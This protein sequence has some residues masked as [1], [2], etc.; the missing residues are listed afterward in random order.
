MINGVLIDR[1]V[2]DVIPALKTNLEGLSKVLEDLVKQYKAK[3]EE[4]EKWKVVWSP[5]LTVM[6]L[7]A[8]IIGKVTE[9]DLLRE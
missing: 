8:D 6:F 9:A 7:D 4:M 2:K 5:I 1:T 3:Q